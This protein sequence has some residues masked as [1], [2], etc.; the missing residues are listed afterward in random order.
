MTQKYFLNVFENRAIEEHLNIQPIDS[1]WAI[2]DA[3]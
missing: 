3:N 2:N 1:C